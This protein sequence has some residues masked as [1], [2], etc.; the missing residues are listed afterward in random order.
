M[1]DLIMFKYKHGIEAVGVI[2]CDPHFFDV[3]AVTVVRQEL[4][5]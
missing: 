2:I 1:A 4:K 5:T 3:S